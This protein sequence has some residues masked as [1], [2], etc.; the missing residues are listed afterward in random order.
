MP[1]NEELQKRLEELE[2]RVIGLEMKPSVVLTYPAHY[3]FP[4]VYYPPYVTCGDKT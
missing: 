2:R 4:P 3:Y 1:S